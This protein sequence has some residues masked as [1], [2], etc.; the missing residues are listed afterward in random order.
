MALTAAIAGASAVSAAD[1][2]NA[3]NCTGNSACIATGGILY[4]YIANPNTLPY[5]YGVPNGGY[6]YPYNPYYG[7]GAYGY[8]YGAGGYYVPGP[9]YYYG[10]CLSYDHD[11]E[12]P[13][14][15]YYGCGGLSN[16]PCAPPRPV[17]PAPGTPASPVPAA[18]NPPAAAPAVAPKP[19]P[20]PQTSPDSSSQLPVVADGK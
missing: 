12:V 15:P 7:N 9:Y 3:Q 18:S 5:G 2:Y 14:S 16:I 6:G 10:S 8:G 19:V 20:Y 1:P 4:P 17:A 13:G 11:C